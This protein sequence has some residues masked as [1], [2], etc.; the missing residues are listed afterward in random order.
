M[1]TGGNG[2]QAERSAMRRVQKCAPC[3]DRNVDGGN[4]SECECRKRVHGNAR[5]CRRKDRVTRL[6]S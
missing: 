6:Q 5:A 2:R 1:S 3:E 4:V